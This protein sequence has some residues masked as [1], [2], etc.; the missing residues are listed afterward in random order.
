MPSS[1]RAVRT[2]SCAAILVTLACA[3]DTVAPEHVAGV[4]VRAARSYGDGGGA[5]LDGGVVTFEGFAL[6]AIHGQQDWQATGGVGSGAAPGSYCAVYDHAIADYVAM[7][8]PDFRDAAFGARSLRMSNAV[9]TGCYSDQ[10]FSHRAADV[11]G[12]IGA[13]SRSR[14]GLTDYALAGARLRNHLE[15]EWSIQSAVPDEWQPGL[16]LAASPA[17]GDDHRMSWVLVADWMDGLAV[18]FAER[19]DPNA[20]AAFVQTTVARGLDRRRAHAIRLSMDFVDGP[21]NDIVRVYVDGALRHT[22]TSWE[23]YYNYDA[24]GRANFGGATPAVNRV[25][26]RTGSDRHRGVPGDPAPETLG[27][28]FLIDGVRVAV[29]S[30]ATSTASCRDNGWQAVHDA[31]GR[32]F[33]NQGDC[34]SWVQSAQRDQ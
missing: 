3:R 34:V 15:L 8:P 33:R 13:S 25:M 10:T 18:V 30:V 20:P 1:P 26:F 27:R 29:F 9:T 6:G 32:P 31:L 14:D 24:N 17:R 22:G 23:A 11:A 28:G 4:P 16:E 19:S 7:V 2:L 5:P 21:A 12:E